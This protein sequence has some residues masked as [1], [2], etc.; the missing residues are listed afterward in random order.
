ML[1]IKVLFEPQI[2]IATKED[3]VADVVIPSEMPQLIQRLHGVADVESGHLL[4]SR[5][6]PV[7]ASDGSR[8]GNEGF[9]SPA[10]AGIDARYAWRFLGGDDV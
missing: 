5:S 10:P 6:T 4:Q 2:S 7:N 9:L 8:S 1:G 3:K